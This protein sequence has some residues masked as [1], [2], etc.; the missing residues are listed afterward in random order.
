MSQV[1]GV[2]VGDLVVRDGMA[3]HEPSGRSFRHSV[4]VILLVGTALGFTVVLDDAEA[5]AARRMRA[6]LR[7]VGSRV[8]VVACSHHG[9]RLS[10]ERGAAPE[11][12]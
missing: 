3:L 7:R 9:Y 5:E 8:Q 1:T 2:R 6:W 11:E 4:G 10:A 12:R